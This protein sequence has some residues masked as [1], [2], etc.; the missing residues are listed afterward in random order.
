MRGAMRRLEPCLVAAVATMSLASC[1]RGT[2]AVASEV[3]TSCPATA[4]HGTGLTLSALLAGGNGM[5]GPR[6]WLRVRQQRQLTREGLPGDDSRQRVRLVSPESVAGAAPAEEESAVL[7][8][9]TADE[10]VSELGS[11]SAVVVVR[12]AAAESV[13]RAVASLRPDGSVAFLGECASRHLTEPYERFVAHRHQVGDSRGAVELF[14]ALAKDPALVADLRTVE[15]PPRPTP[16]AWDA[17]E[18]ALRVIDPDG[19]APPPPAVMAGLRPHLVHFVYPKAWRSFEGSIVTFVPGV[20][21]N[22][23]LPL[24]LDSADPSVLAYASLTTPLEIWVVPA[25]AGI[26]QPLARLAVVDA[27]ALAALDEVRFH[28]QVD[29]TSLDDLVRQA[30]A[31]KVVFALGPSA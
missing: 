29:A 24:S 9:S 8:R 27:A 5:A 14:Y 7:F 3:G 23:A 20:G 15:S 30:K 4:G 10:A 11:G 2:G 16:V 17:R 21:W 18:P 22:A 19:N 6:D 28:A 12:P 31:G 26:G 1:G 25:P 13:A